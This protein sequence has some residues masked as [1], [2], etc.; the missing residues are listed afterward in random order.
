MNV[1]VP[2]KFVKNKSSSNLELVNTK[3]MY[4]NDV[5]ENKYFTFQ[6]ENQLIALS[7]DLISKFPS[8]ERNKN[9]YIVNSIF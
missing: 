6:V 9:D 7:F 4:N 3:F 2:N 8:I 5:N 1:P